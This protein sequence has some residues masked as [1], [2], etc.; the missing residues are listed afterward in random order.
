MLDSIMPIAVVSSTMSKAQVRAWL[1][2][3]CAVSV[4]FTLPSSAGWC[5]VVAQYGKWVEPFDW[6]LWACTVSVVFLP[7]GGSTPTG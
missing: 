7:G 6:A 4:C 5:E 2:I 1:L 3:C